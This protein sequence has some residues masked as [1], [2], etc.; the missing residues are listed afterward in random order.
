[1]TTAATTSKFLSLFETSFLITRL[2]PYLRNRASRLIKSPKLYMSDSGLACYLSGVDRVEPVSNEPLM[3]AMFETYV[4]QNFLNL[5]DSRWPEARLFFWSIQG[6][7]EVDFVVESGTH[8]IAIEIKSGT[9]WQNRDLFGL[10]AFLSMTP[11]CKAAILGYNG[12]DS[13]RLGEK[14]WVLPLSLLLF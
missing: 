9:R 3:G 8:C 13:V 2:S 5:I 14:L 10:R 4:A 12:T 11:H 6:R 1:M 7:Q